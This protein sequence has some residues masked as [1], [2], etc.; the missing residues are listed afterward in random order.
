MARRAGLHHRG[1]LRRVAF[2]AHVAG[3]ADLSAITELHVARDR[4]VGI[5]AIG[6]GIANVALVVSAALAVQASGDARG[7]F[8]DQLATMPGVRDRVDVDRIVRGVLV[9][10]PF[11]AM[12]RRSTTDG[13]LLVG[14]AA[15]FFDPFTGEGICCALQGAELA[16]DTLDEVLARSGAITAHSL[17]GYRAAR[18]RAFFG[19]WLVERII[20]YGMFAP[21]LFDRAMA[22]M[23]RRGMADTLFGVTGHLVSPWRV[24]NPLFLARMMV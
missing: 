16:A 4:Y 14:D 24:L 11:D 22:R 23:E 19:K 1:R 8:R 10:G 2:G 5:S 21:T 3:V 18:R 7:F 15:D 12:A 13:A 17:R 20:G 9:T 6:G